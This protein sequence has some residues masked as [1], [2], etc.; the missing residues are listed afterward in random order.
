[1]TDTSSDLLLV[2]GHSDALIDVVDRFHEGDASR[3]AEFHL[4]RWRDG[5]VHAA[6]C[7]IWVDQ[8][9]P[10]RDPLSVALRN[11][12][13]I[14]RSVDA[15]RG[16]AVVALSPADV[17]RAKDSGTFAVLLGMEGAMPL[18]GDADLLRVFLALGLRWVGLTWNHRNELGDG[19]GVPR[20]G[21]LTPQGQEVVSELG[22]IGLVLDLTHASP[23]TLAEATRLSSTPVLVS[24]SNARAL[25]NHPRNL[26]D[27]QIR[28]V[29]E[30]G[31]VIGV[32]FFPSLV[33][34]KEPSLR[35]VVRQLAYLED[36][37]GP[38]HVSLGPDYIDYSLDIMGASL[39]SS[40]MD[41]GD[42]LAYP[43]GVEDTTKLGPFVSSLPE[44]GVSPS[45]VANIAGQSLLTLFDTVQ[46]RSGG[47]RQ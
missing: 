1:M 9:D 20:P 46:A 27:E 25:R 38:G 35:D 22:R 40:G 32:N 28:Q 36:V 7:P 44:H 30:A 6:L 17:V 18:Q 42:D 33:A 43:S 23:P 34:E 31:G 16:E 14:L 3:L 15:S 29:A 5:G 11:L 2:D 41:Y 21:G 37:A 39:H 10:T 8:T 24:H 45:E 13:V 12:D 4:P 47:A 26:D 19:L